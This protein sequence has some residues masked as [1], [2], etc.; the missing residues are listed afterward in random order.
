MK[1]RKNIYFYT[2][3]KPW[4]EFPWI[5]CDYNGEWYFEMVFFKRCFVWNIAYTA[6]KEYES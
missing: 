3:N 5:R 2:V 1:P 6:D 4:F